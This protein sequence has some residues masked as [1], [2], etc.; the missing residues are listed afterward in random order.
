MSARHLLVVEADPSVRQWFQT[1]F[2][3]DFV[4]TLVATSVEAQTKLQVESY[5]LIFLAFELSEGA[6]LALL[7]EI[8]EDGRFP[9]ARHTPVIMIASSGSADVAEACFMYDQCTY[10]TKPLQYEAVDEAIGY[11][12]STA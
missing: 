2:G 11:A 5:T 3:P 10:V 7:R 1:I 9:E 6:S 4:L 12:L 8:R